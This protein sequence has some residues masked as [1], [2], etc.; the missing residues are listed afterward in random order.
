MPVSCSKTL[1]SGIDGSAAFIP[2]ATRHCLLDFT[3]FPVG[4][5]ITVPNSH[6]YL[7]GDPVTFTPQGSAS[8]DGALTAGT[9]YYVVAATHGADPYISV[10]ATAGGAAITLDG[11]GG[12]GTADSASSAA[13]HILVQFASHLAICQ[14]QSWS[15]NLTREEVMTTS[16][17]CGPTTGGGVN[18]PFMTRQ[19]G[20][21]DG[22]GS[23]VVRFSRDQES[24][25]RRLLRNS[26]RKNQDGA[27]VQLFIDTAYDGTGA[28]NL[29]G[30]EYIE[31]P[32]SVLGFQL[33][34]AVGSEP[35]QGTINFSFSDQPTNIFGAI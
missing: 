15:C 13:N 20:Y 28:V 11:D 32:V 35:T 29:S 7:V 12:T 3:D 30:S 8:L 19:G 23:M 33:G 5:Q 10:S 1:L 31:G 17:Q 27:S 21:V 16:L 9:T 22:S 6:D 2:A 18:A 34:V 14:V 4:N 24:L 26:L 25:S